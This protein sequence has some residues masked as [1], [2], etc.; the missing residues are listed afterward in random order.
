[1]YVYQLY[2]MDTNE[3]IS[4]PSSSLSATLSALNGVMDSPL[5]QNIHVLIR[6]VGKDAGLEEVMALPEWTRDFHR[7]EG[8]MGNT[9]RQQNDNILEWVR[10]SFVAIKAP[11]LIREWP[12]FHGYAF[13]TDMD[14]AMAEVLSRDCQYFSYSPSI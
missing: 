1:M 8:L 10:K 5:N 2:D 12:H 11:D 13:I 9:A 7:L 4:H 6:G 14:I 3:L